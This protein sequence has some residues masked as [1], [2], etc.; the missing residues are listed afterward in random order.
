[1]RRQ[2]R[3]CL[4]LVFLAA[5]IPACSG[6]ARQV[7]ETA[8]AEFRERCSRSAFDEIYAAS[9]PDLWTSATKDDFLKLMNGVKRKLGPWRSSTSLGWRVMS[10]TGG[11]TVTLG[12]QSAFEKGTATEEF[13]WRVEDDRAALVGYHINSP[14]FLAE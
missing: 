13:V 3:D 11:R 2:L 6:K 1:M 14:V 4:V 5:V 9:A 10:G 8:T 12:F 7:A